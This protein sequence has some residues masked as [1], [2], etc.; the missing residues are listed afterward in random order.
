MPEYN[1]REFLVRL[2]KGVIIPFSSILKSPLIKIN[3][4]TRINGNINI[5]GKGEC[6]IGKYC[7]IGYDVRIITST[8]E[9]RFANLQTAMHEKNNF[10][11]QLEIT[12]GD[13]NVGNNVWIGDNVTILNGVSIG[14]GAI[15]GASSTVTKNVEPYTIV[16]GNPAKI[17]SS[18][19]EEDVIKT[20]NKICWWDWDEEK[21]RKNEK[22]FTLDLTCT[23][24]SKIIQS[25]V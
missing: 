15:L 19:F 10:G 25:I 17:I 23:S 8:H 16:A 11:K 3:D 4:Y 9:Y 24:N 6:H 20:L 14:D 12:K 1:S 13:V 22:F 7:A 2:G 5:R 21:I 18:R